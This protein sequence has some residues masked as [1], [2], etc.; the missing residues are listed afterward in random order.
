MATL[1][2]GHAL[3]EAGQPPASARWASQ[4][5]I[6]TFDYKPGDIW[7]GT[8]RRVPVEAHDIAAAL[9]KKAQ[10]LAS[11]QTF[12][13]TWRMQQI[14]QC[15]AHIKALHCQSLPVGIGDDMHIITGAGTRGGKGTT[16]IIPNL[17]LYPGSV[18]CIDP[19]GENARITS[20]RRGSGN[21]HVEGMGQDVYVLDPYR[22]SGV[23]ER[24]QGSWNA[25]D[26]IDLKSADFYDQASTIVQSLLVRS[27]SGAANAEHFDE[28]AAAIIKALILLVK[29]TRSGHDDCNLLTVR[30]YLLNGVQAEDLPQDLDLDEEVADG[31]PK[32]LE[33]MSAIGEDLDP[34]LVISGSA[35]TLIDM[36]SNEFG[37][38]LSTARRQLAF[39]ERLPMARVVEKSSFSLDE[40][41]TAPKGATIYL[42]LPAQRMEDCGRWLRLLIGSSLAR[43][44]ELPEPAT[45][46]PVL[47]LLEEFPVLKHMSEIEQGMAYG[48]GFGIKF[49]II[50]QDLSQLKRYYPKSWETFIGNA[51]ALQ[52]FA[53]NDG[54]TLEFFSKRCGDLEIVQ[55]NASMN[56]SHSMNSADPSQQSRL[57]QLF[58]NR[59]QYSALLNP[60]TLLADSKST[61]H[62]STS[63][64]SQSDARQIV[65]LIRPDEMER[66]FRREEMAQA[67]F[68]KGQRPMALYREN[69]FDAPEFM[70]LYWPDRGDKLN[71]EQV[72]AMKKK[73]LSA[74]D[75]KQ[76]R[77]AT[78]ARTYLSSLEQSL[79]AAMKRNG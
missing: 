35:S 5:E 53:N 68:I 25:L 76:E 55:K 24:Y 78:A 10:Q 31:M 7:L 74:R 4:E 42:C 61:T 46:L 16:T 60:F 66:A 41:K 63:A 17:C 28:S 19:K 44:Y 77:I 1:P 21:E 62:S 32:L 79:S 43:L 57:Q 54:T 40:L 14:K 50:I 71:L 23:E 26:S 8:R 30:R 75:T 13:Q 34:S 29:I 20:A 22:I 72:A 47:Y 58:Q 6:A 11:D 15:R 27:S 2:R 64:L 12:E 3:S 48:A 33:Y 59:G 38:V 36:G 69:Y 67:V 18:I 49:H 65:R 39:L 9:Q 51:G 56:T 37:S 52:M 45:E 73:I 70:G